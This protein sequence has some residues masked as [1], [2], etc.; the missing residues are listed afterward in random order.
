MPWKHPR[1][2]S[3]WS[4]TRGSIWKEQHLGLEQEQQGNGAE[5]E[6]PHQTTGS[7]AL[8]QVVRG[9]IKFEVLLA[10]SKAWAKNWGKF[11]HM[12]FAINYISYHS[13]I[14]VYQEHLE[15]I[16]VAFQIALHLVYTYPGQFQT[17]Q[18]WYLGIKSTNKYKIWTIRYLHSV[19]A[20]P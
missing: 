1:K 10:V 3:L 8:L 7:S 9:E 15:N 5:Q 2:L 18:W 14:A 11:I 13:P 4:Q 6:F 19:F 12:S 16:H 20:T 17:S